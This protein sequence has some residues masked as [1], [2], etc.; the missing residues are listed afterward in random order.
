MTTCEECGGSGR[1][2]F[3]PDEPRCESCGGTGCGFEAAPPPAPKPVPTVLWQDDW[4]CMDCGAD[5]RGESLSRTA[6]ERAILG[7][8]CVARCEACRAF[9]MRM[10]DAGQDIDAA[11][12]R[13]YEEEEERWR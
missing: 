5:T 12:S 11:R 1:T 2:P 13:E 4:S 9:R 6:A 10:W 7:A 8:L 3:I